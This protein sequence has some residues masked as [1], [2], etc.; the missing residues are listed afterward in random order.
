MKTYIKE[1]LF[2]VFAFTIS[3][4]L[5]YITQIEIVK[6][7]VLLA[8]IIQ[9]VLFIPAY[10]FQTEKFYD[11]SGSITYISVV[12]YSFYNSYNS[13]D[14]NLGNII[15]SLLIIVWAIR[16]GSFLFIRIKKA[17]E[18]IRFREIKKSPSR[19]FM[20]WTLQGMWVSI[21]SACALAGIANGIEINSYFY[22]GLLIFT[23]GFITEII[24]DNQK[25]KFRRDPINKDKF[26]TSGIWK[27][28]R[29][30][31]YLG[32]I[33]L[34]LGISVISFSSLE[35]L[36][37]VTLISPIFT[38]LLLVYVSGVRI[39]EYNGNKK[40]GHLDSYKKYKEKTPRLIGFL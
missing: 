29:H 26:I 14:L 32:E 11:L 31:N 39:L 2:A 35:G 40:W 19:F 1:I 16:L 20:T 10:M 15:L 8:F 5:A 9:W 13:N 28:S 3:F 36:E 4:S 17:G 12:S 34:W 7:A 25:I 6:N 22:T 23:L 21:C 18:D 33:T 38:Y 27:Y 24:A 30:P 37:L